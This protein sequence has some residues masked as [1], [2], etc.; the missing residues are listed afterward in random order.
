MGGGSGGSGSGGRGGGGGG[1]DQLYADMRSG[2]VNMETFNN[3]LRNIKT[4]AIQAEK[5]GNMAEG[6]KLRAQYS[7]LD[8]VRTKF[9][10]E[11]VARQQF[12]N[13]FY[14]KNKRLPTKAE[15]HAAGFTWV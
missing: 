3:D 13:K 11:N 14:M 2:K 6:A 1:A 15:Q 9:G 5:G 4:A 12:E 8:A 7:K 10:N